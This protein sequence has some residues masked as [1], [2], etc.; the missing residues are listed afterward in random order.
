P[1]PSSL[2]T[3][4]APPQ[5]STLS[6]HDAL[7]ISTPER[8][9][10]TGEYD[11]DGGLAADAPLAVKPP[12]LAGGP[13]PTFE[14]SA[15]GRKLHVGDAVDLAWEPPPAG[16]DFY[17]VAYSADGGGRWSSLASGSATGYRFV[18]PDTA[19]S[20]LIEVVARRGD[21]V[22]GTWLSAPLPSH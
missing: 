11:A 4:P 9:T 7:P 13:L 14:S 3:A 5:I 17:D 15:H 16:A 10:L 18:A 22:L 21:T 12:P 2:Y 1:L 19:A 6:L 20:A 8:F